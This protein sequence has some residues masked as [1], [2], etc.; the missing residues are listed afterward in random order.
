MET[1]N[2]Q[3]VQGFILRGYGHLKD[4]RYYLLNAG[5]AALGKKWLDQISN[6]ITDGTAKPAKTALN[7]AFTHA[8]LKALG[9]K[10]ANLRAFAREFRE[11][12]DT[13]HRNRL[14]GDEGTSGP[15]NWVFGSNAEN[16]QD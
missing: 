14:L 15:K 5:N 6:D 11:G 16:A 13:A 8:G 7:I 4:S 12:M 3:D 1:I 10:E 2:K 9:M